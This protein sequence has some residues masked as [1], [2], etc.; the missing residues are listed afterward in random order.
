MKVVEVEWLDA[1][2]Q[3]GQINDPSEILDGCII[4]TVGYLV[5]ENKDTITLA[6]EFMADD[7]LRHVTTIPKAIIKKRR[8]I[9][10]E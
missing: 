2:F 4:S 10:V 9:G 3:A 5:K 7:T 6:M 8:K 1:V